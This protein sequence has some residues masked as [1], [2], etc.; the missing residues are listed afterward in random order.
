MEQSLDIGS[1]RA[2]ARRLCLHHCAAV[3]SVQDSGCLAE[4]SGREQV[5]KDIEELRLRR[6]GAMVFC[7]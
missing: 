6:I 1:T 4:T 5:D 7:P 3:N 2:L